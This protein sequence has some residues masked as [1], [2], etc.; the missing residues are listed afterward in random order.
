[1]ETIEISTDDFRRLA[2]RRGQRVRDYFVEQKIEGER[3][4]LTNVPSD[5]KGTRVY[6]QLQ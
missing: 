4:F 6:L 1:M 2:A 3:L 5:G